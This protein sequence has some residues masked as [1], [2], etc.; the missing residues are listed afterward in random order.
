MMDNTEQKIELEINI[1]DQPL[2]LMVTPERRKK[3]Q[4]LETELNNLYKTWRLRFPRK[5]ETELIAMIAYQYAS[6]YQELTER[7]REA[8]KIAAQIEADLPDVNF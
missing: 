2:S 8:Q 5:T 7:Y 1:G 6:Y 4:E 3:V